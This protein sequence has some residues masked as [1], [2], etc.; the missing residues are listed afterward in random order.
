VP[1]TL[2]GRVEG[3]DRQVHLLLTG[4]QLC[5]KVYFLAELLSPPARC[6]NK[7]QAMNKLL[8]I[9]LATLGGWLGWWLGAFLGTATGFMLSLVGMG[10]GLY[11]GRRMAA[12]YLG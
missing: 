5:P 3:G 1:E 10:I 12:Y 6:S 4:I 11:L 2:L 8:A 9:L 7:G